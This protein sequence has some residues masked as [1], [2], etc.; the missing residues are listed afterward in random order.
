MIH[1]VKGNLLDSNCDYICHQVNCKG[2][3][4]AGIAKQIRDRWPEVYRYYMERFWDRLDDSKTTEENMLGSIDDVKIKNDTRDLHIVNMYAQTSYGF[5][6]YRYTSYDA[7]EDCL[8]QI[9]RLVP[10]SK[11]IG[12]PKGIGC[13][14]GGGDWEIIL[15]MIETVLG[16]THEVFIY[17]L[18]E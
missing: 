3:M 1:H 5:N 14:L 11:M 4:G 2:V 17:E 15:R 10:V 18:E 8:Y 13:G 7:F 9:K 6:H 12:F 16:D